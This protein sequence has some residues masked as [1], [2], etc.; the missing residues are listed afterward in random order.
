MFIVSVGTPPLPPAAVADPVPA[1]REDTDATLR[2]YSPEVRGE[3][4]LA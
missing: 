1:C 2:G 4:L 3:H